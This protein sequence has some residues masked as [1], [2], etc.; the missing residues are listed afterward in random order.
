MESENRSLRRQ[1]VNLQYENTYMHKITEMQAEIISL[2]QQVSNLKKENKRLNQLISNKA[3]KQCE[4]LSSD[5]EYYSADEG[6]A[7]IDHICKYCG[8]E[9]KYP[10]N[11][12]Q[13]FTRKNECAKK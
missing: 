12:R 1:I 6:S 10:S 5:E 2:K 13:H 4:E 9:F 8:K 7:K 11:L 3:S